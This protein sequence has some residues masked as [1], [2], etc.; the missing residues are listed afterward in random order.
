MRSTAG[1]LRDI[2]SLSGCLLRLGV[3]IGVAAAVVALIPLSIPGIAWLHADV[4]LGWRFPWLSWPPMLAFDGWFGWFVVR[5][6]L[7]Q[8]WLRR[9]WPGR[10][11]ARSF[12]CPRCD[13]L[14]GGW[15]GSL[16]RC[17]SPDP[18]SQWGDPGPPEGCF[19]LRCEACEQ[20]IPFVLWL[21]GT[22][23]PHIGWLL[24][25]KPSV[26]VD[27]DDRPDFREERRVTSPR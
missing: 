15:A 19:R 14:L 24:G 21:D 18:F 27:L 4:L 2:L 11:A 6:Q 1:W 13:G 10:L 9:E 5:T 17:P 7:E 26:V 12:C 8:R 23:S 22:V 25:N 3:G 16:E 20:D